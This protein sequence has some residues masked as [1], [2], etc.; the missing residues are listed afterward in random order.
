MMTFVA[1]LTIAAAVI[2][3]RTWETQRHQTKPVRIRSDEQIQRQRRT[4]R[5]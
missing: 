5:Y 2:L 4:R 1:L 3:L